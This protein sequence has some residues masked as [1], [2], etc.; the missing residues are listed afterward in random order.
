MPL[1]Q[2]VSG[3]RVHD[4][5]AN[6][7]PGLRSCKSSLKSSLL[8]LWD[9]ASRW[10]AGAVEEGPHSVSQTLRD[11]LRRGPRHFAPHRQAKT[12]L[13]NS[14]TDGLTDCLCGDVFVDALPLAMLRSE[15]RPKR[16]CALFRA[17]GGP[18]EWL[19]DLA[20]SFS[21]SFLRL[22]SSF[23]VALRAG[24]RRGDSAG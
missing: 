24:R 10:R 8:V 13:K 4:H 20:S 2:S 23:L 3:P 22:L 21:S 17:L 12:S 5:V 9:A 18:E 7:F 16:V 1:C 11:R 6:L 14:L 15:E 19:A